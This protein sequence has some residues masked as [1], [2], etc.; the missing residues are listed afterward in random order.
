VHGWGAR[1]GHDKRVVLSYDYEQG[2]GC[3]DGWMVE[4]G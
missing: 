4:H 3:E 1:F 2:H